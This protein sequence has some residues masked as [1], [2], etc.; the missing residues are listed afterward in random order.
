MASSNPHHRGLQRRRRVQVLFFAIVLG[1][2]L[3]SAPTTVLADGLVLTV[4]PLYSIPLTAPKDVFTSAS[5]G[6]SL[7]VSLPFSLFGLPW[8]TPAAGFGYAYSGLTATTGSLSA[9]EARAGLAA[10]APAT[11]WLDIAAGLYLH[12]GYYLLSAPAQSASGFSPG[13]SAEAGADFLL[14]QLFSV[15]LGVQGV[16]DFGMYA[17]LRPF[18]SASVH[19]L[20]GGPAQGQA[21]PSPPQRPAPLSE[22]EQ[23]S[24]RGAGL[25]L[26]VSPLYSLPLG[27]P[28][29]VL[30]TESFGGSLS[31]SLPF[32]LFGAS[33]LTPAVGFGYVYSGLT[34][35]TG[36]LSAIEGQAGLS[37]RIPVVPWMDLATGVF[38]RGG[39]Y[40]LNAPSQSTSGFSPGLSL[41]AGTDFRLGSTISLG[42]GVQGVYDFGMYGYLRPYLSASVHL[43]GG[44]A[45]GQAEPQP[46]PSPAPKPAPL[47]G[48][49][50]QK[51]LPAAQDA[52]ALNVTLDGVFPVFYKYYADH[53]FG[54]VTISNKG[55]SPWTDVKVSFS[56]RQFMDLPSTLPPIPSIP[57]GQAVKVD[58]VSLFNDSILSVTEATK[59]SGELVVEYKENGKPA[60]LSNTIALRVY[61]R[62]AMTWTDDRRAAA[63]ITAKD[64]VIL[65]FA[66]GLA[67]DVSASRNTAISDR[68]QVVAGVH[69]A[70]SIYGVNYVP[71]PTSIFA[72]SKAKTEVDFLQFPRQTLEYRAGDCD[73]LSILYSALLEAVGIESALITVPG[74]IFIAASLDMAPDDAKARF[75]RVDEL[76]FKD[77]KTWL[78]VEVTI[79]KGGFL[80]AW[81][82]GAREWRESSARGLAAFF[83]VRGAWDLYEPVALPGSAT[84]PP[85]QNARAVEAVKSVV[86]AFI[87]SEI[88]ERAARL[89]ADSRKARGASKAIN[90]LG[91]LYAQ[92]GLYSKA[93]AQFESV[94]ARE[95]YVPALLNLGHIHRLLGDSDAA[96]RYYDRALKKAPTNPSVLL[97]EAVINHQMENYGVVKRYY[98]E[99]KV[100]DP[101][102]ADRYAFLDLKGEEGAK[103][104]DA[105][106]L[107]TMVEWMEGK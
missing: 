27:A 19:L 1:F 29:D 90:S 34:A 65:S 58:L 63:F 80:S 3:S 41:E 86:E 22:R 98:Q 85:L 99:L 33:W 102:L 54:S 14:G 60:R 69:E 96:L 35:T 52:E 24:S 42:L 40:L 12:G 51:A 23:G 100:Q 20:G 67:G 48:D 5:L 89:Q 79:R 10:R 78:P 83:P 45:Q 68:L 76:I 31:A 46:L 88:A 17:Y 66:K 9:I 104:A 13:L 95:E 77:G 56:M 18:L 30:S 107:K 73:D 53:A 101:A 57:A 72:G 50:E 87:T 94:L 44:T 84:L 103:A 2:S 8:L 16:Y 97:A 106:G 64:P 91:V 47:V 11:P 39:Y 28:K 37:A 55:R 32:G 74:H 105:S 25:V 62:N 26:T 15:G 75:S 93:R 59:I 38:L 4:A 7:T 43:L 70:L 71:D 49:T 21:E 82:E 61:D 92:Y 36:S 6:G 81:A